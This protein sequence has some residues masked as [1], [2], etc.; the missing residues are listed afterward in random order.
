MF[1]PNQSNN[2]LNERPNSF[3]IN[4]ESS[5]TNWG[6]EFADRC[7]AFLKDDTILRPKQRVVHED[8]IA[9]LRRGETGGHVRRPTGS[10]KTFNQ[11]ALAL[12]AN[13]DP[14]SGKFLW[15]KPVL[16]LTP[17]CFLANDVFTKTFCEAFAIPKA[18]VGVYHSK[19]D[20]KERKTSL[21]KPILITTPQSWMALLDKRTISIDQRPLV[22]LD[23]VHLLRGT[24][25]KP[26]I[27]QARED[28]IVLGWTATD[29]FVT[30][31]TVGDV[32]FDGKPAIHVTTFKEAVEGGEL[33]AVKNFILETGLTSGLKL[34]S[35]RS[36]QHDYSA[37]ERTLISNLAGRDEMALD[38]FFNYVDQKT[39]IKFRN[40]STVFF[41]NGIKHADEIASKINRS[42]GRDNFAKTVSGETSWKELSKHLEDFRRGKIRVLTCADLLIHGLDAP[43][44]QLCIMLRPTRS[45]IIAEQTGGRIMRLNPE[46]SNKMAYVVTLIDRDV[47]ELKVF[48]HCAGAMELYSPMIDVYGS[49]EVEEITAA[50]NYQ[51]SPENQNRKLIDS[52]SELNEFLE[53]R[54]KKQEEHERKNTELKVNHFCK[55]QTLAKKLG[56]KENYAIELHALLGEISQSLEEDV[57]FVETT[58]YGKKVRIPRDLIREFSGNSGIYVIH[59][60]AVDLLDDQLQIRISKRASNKKPAGWKMLESLEDEKNIPN[61]EDNARELSLALE[62]LRNFPFEPPTN[63]QFYGLLVPSDKIGD[64]LFRRRRV[65]CVDEEWFDKLSTHISQA[66]NIEGKFSKS[67][68]VD[69]NLPSHVNTDISWKKEEFKNYYSQL[70]KPTI[71]RYME[72]FPE[73]DYVSKVQNIQLKLVLLINSQLPTRSSLSDLSEEERAKI[74]YQLA[75]VLWYESH[76]IELPKTKELF[77]MNE[78]QLLSLIDGLF[79]TDNFDRLRSQLWFTNPVGFE[80]LEQYFLFNL[81]KELIASNLLMSEEEVDL[82]ISKIKLF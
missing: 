42:V 61:F 78:E 29:R 35:K 60:S 44:A 82:Q 19:I 21:S 32:L 34:R 13:L 4:T 12:A 52:E 65:I 9:D 56:I 37:F 50:I 45:P 64:F 7:E 57:S 66:S 10:G 24:I 54:V 5:L 6:Y 14:N 51:F 22:L 18:Y 48:G 28:N 26:R 1:V 76:E 53:K 55:P 63:F 23:E 2:Q 75:N 71:D 49:P 20:S 77:S 74:T 69:S 8:I 40:L 30:G 68:T 70:C 59:R 11:A 46:C 81:K 3:R 58:F 33:C 79:I 72:H 39:D 38:V 73:E 27:R 67:S 80:I 43:R 31:E 36:S 62:Q 41:C 25:T 17:R 15:D 16:Y 47:F